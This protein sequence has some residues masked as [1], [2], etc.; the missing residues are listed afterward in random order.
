MRNALAIRII[1][2]GI[3]NISIGIG[4]RDSA[5]AGIEV[6]G[7]ECIALFFSN[8][9]MTVYILCRIAIGGFAKKLAQFAICVIGICRISVRT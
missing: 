4:D 5:A 6:V 3:G 7:L 2:K 1:C 8:E 9:S